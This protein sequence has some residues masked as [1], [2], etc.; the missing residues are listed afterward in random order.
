[1]PPVGSFTISSAN[2]R[3]E[4]RKSPTNS[5][6]EAKVLHISA[7]PLEQLESE[8]VLMAGAEFLPK[9]FTSTILLDKLSHI[10]SPL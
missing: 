10:L 3:A 9:P 1:M 5:A 2:R 6:D 8:G 7:Y 4:A